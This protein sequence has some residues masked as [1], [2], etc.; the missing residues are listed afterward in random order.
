M[1]AVASKTM[2]YLPI[3]QETAESARRTMRDGFGHELAVTSV[4]APCRACLRIPRSPE[5]MI[6]LSYR[7]LEDTNPYAEIGPIFIHAE[8]CEPY[9]DV[10]EFPPD[11]AARP[12]VVRAYDRD[13]RIADAA[14]AE[15]GEAPAQ[16]RRFLDDDAIA[17]VH[18]R[19][20]SYTC[21]DFRIVRA[22]NVREMS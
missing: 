10:T 15:P 17:E 5:P 16:A 11:F 20:V 8:A 12:L 2:H 13:G 18:V 21:Y 19:H 14:V 3:P 22:G 4:V 9:S 6:L 1:N 7:P